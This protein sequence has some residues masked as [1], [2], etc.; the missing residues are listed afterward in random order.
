MADATTV[1]ELLHALWAAD[2]TLNGLLPAERV[3]TGWA[4]PGTMPYAVLSQPAGT[5]AGQGHRN[6][7]SNEQWRVQVWSAGYNAGLA[8]R[9]AVEDC[10]AN[11]DASLTTG[12]VVRIRFEGSFNL[13]E[14][15]PTA[16]IWQFVTQFSVVVERPRAL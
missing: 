4:P 3:F 5:P 11:A 15:D 12:G 14:E 13:P 7:W 16:T 10:L 1:S 2:A 9:Q 6:R 8:I